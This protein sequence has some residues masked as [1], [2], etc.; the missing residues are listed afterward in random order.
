MPHKTTL[1]RT[2]TAIIIVTDNKIKSLLN[3]GL[4]LVEFLSVYNIK[5][6]SKAV[7]FSAVITQSSF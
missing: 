2:T 3:Y 5:Q 4:T 7:K 6:V 1:K